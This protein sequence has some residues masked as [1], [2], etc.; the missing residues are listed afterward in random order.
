MNVLQEYIYPKIKKTVIDAVV[1]EGNIKI[2][3]LSTTVRIS[4]EGVYHKVY[5]KKQFHLNKEIHNTPIYDDTL[6]DMM[7]SFYVEVYRYINFYEGFKE[8]LKSVIDNNQISEKERLKLI[9]NLRRETGLINNEVIDES[10]N[11][12]LEL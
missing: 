11:T 3:T 10:N 4:V 12:G 6:L 2:Y 1:G 8:P 7:E 9:Y 5:M